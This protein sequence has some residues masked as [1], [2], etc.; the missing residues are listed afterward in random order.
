MLEDHAVG[1]LLLALGIF[2]L[3]D[4]VGG[5]ERPVP[6]HGPAPARAI[7][8]RQRPPDDRRLSDVERLAAWSRTSRL[9]HRALNALACSM[10]RKSCA[11]NS[12]SWRARAALAEVFLERRRSWVRLVHDLAAIRSGVPHR[13]RALLALGLVQRH[14]RSA[15]LAPRPEPVAG[16]P[17][18]GDSGSNCLRGWSGLRTIL[19]S[20]T[21]MTS[22]LGHS[23]PACRHG[24]RSEHSCR[25]APSR[26]RR[27]SRRYSPHHLFRGR[28]VSASRRPP[29]WRPGILACAESA[30]TSSASAF[31]ALVESRRGFLAERDASR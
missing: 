20:G 17:L 10:G 5:R 12:T 29:P 28:R 8:V 31:I 21:S 1:D 9:V 15:E 13:S 16:K 22:A 26:P 2:Y 23:L 3:A 24:R 14:P 4:L 11:S 7:P 25:L 30:A 27:S 6:F 19:S 18:K